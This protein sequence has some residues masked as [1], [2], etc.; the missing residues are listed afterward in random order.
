M[1]YLISVTVL[2]LAVSAGVQSAENK[3]YEYFHYQYDIAVPLSESAVKEIILSVR[4]M[5]GIVLSYD[6]SHITFRVLLKNTVS[7]TEIIKRTGF[8]NDEKT[9]RYDVG[10]ELAVARAQLAVKEEFIAKLYKLTD[11]ADLAGTLNAEKAIEQAL[12]ERDVL[13]STISKYER[14]S[15]YV[16][17]TVNIS[18]PSR[19]PSERSKSRWNFVNNMGVENS[20]GLR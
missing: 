14:M 7:I 18:G 2:L 9:E 1:K 6:D 20:L 15:S 5:S 17:Y 3:Q 12:T 4:L 19:Y 8:I 16:D 13:K 11:D 10:E